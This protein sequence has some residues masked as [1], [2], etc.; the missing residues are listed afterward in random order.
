MK[1]E[2]LGYSRSQE[3]TVNSI[4]LGPRLLDIDMLHRCSV[5]KATLGEMKGGIAGQG[6]LPAQRLYPD[7]CTNGDAM[8]KLEIL[9]AQTCDLQ[10]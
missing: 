7:A 8:E 10:A 2:M 6:W 4:G 3:A 9:E 5:H 1:R